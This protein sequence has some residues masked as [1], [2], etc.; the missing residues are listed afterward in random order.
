M[1]LF[2]LQPG[3]NAKKRI[4]AHTRPSAAAGTPRDRRTALAGLV[5]APNGRPRSVIAFTIR[6]GRIVQIDILADPSRL[7]RFNLTPIGELNGGLG[8]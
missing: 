6:G 4:H 2:S 1:R 3:V 8:T 7:R 5:T